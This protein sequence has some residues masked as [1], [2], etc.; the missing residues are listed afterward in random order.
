MDW[1]YIW[2]HAYGVGFCRYIRAATDSAHSRSH[3]E[4]RRRVDDHR[5]RYAVLQVT[6]FARAQPSRPGSAGTR[7]PTRSQTKIPIVHPEP[8]AETTTM[9]SGV[10]TAGPPRESAGNRGM[11]D[12]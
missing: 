7:R 4:L 11:L 6:A 5:L 1:L 9:R 8:P 2:P 3:G 12:G 10:A